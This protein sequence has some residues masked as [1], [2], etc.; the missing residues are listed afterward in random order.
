MAIGIFK[1]R[2]RSGCL[3]CEG[4]IDPGDDVKWA[5]QSVIHADCAVLDD[6]MRPV[7]PTC[8]N[9]HMVP[10]ANGACDC[11]NNYPKDS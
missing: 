6:T 9:C 1:A 4:C 7:P 5:D 8:P 2:Y 3:A 11:E 10:A